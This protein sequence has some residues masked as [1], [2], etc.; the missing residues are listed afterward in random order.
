MSGFVEGEN[1]Q[2]ATLLCYLSVSMITLQK[3]ALSA[4]FC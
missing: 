2:Q 4:L 1:R 3:K